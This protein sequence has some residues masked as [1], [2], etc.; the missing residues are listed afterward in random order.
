MQVVDRFRSAAFNW[1]CDSY[2]VDIR[3]IVL[4][5][6]GQDFIVSALIQMNPLPSTLDLG[7]KIGMA[8]LSA[9]QCQFDGLSFPKV[10]SII[11]DALK[12]KISVHGKQY[13]LDAEKAYSYY[14]G[15]DAR[16][17]WF[18]DLNFKV[19]ANTQKNFQ[20]ID[21]AS[22]DSM[23]RSGEV[24]FDGLTEMATWL[25]LPRPDEWNRNPS[26][27]IRIAPPADLIFNESSLS[28]DQ[29]KVVLH[30]RPEFDEKKLKLSVRAHPGEGLLSRQLVSSRVCWVSIDGAHKEGVLLIDLKHADSV[31]V[32]VTIGAITVRRQWFSDPI[33]ARNVRLVAT[34]QFDRDLKMLRS[35]VLDAQDSTKF[36]IG[37][38]A[39]FF[40]FGCSASVQSETDSPDLIAVTPGGR[41][42]L[43]ECTLK[44]ADIS[45]KIGKLVDRNIAL[46]KNLS[47]SAHF[48]KTYAVLVCRSSRDQI[49]ISDS[50][51]MELEI[52]LV[53]KDDLLLA[54]D[55]LNHLVSPDEILDAIDMRRQSQTNLVPFGT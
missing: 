7:F 25:G 32:M 42:I 2:S 26:I 17:Q 51:L 27:D 18:S 28:G 35:A 9:G 1:L 46:K 24:P 10:C 6:D 40:L 55:R 23:L 36:E 47:D 15:I 54:F 45:A 3:Y 29:L 19:S 43:V 39:I 11:E 31:L 21:F 20:H 49:A 4:N 14:S 16:D 5:I 30:A 13:A 8:E 52:S 44:T 53:T 41:I 34:R 22:L 38:N 37:I 33:K 48:T 12:G 50:Q